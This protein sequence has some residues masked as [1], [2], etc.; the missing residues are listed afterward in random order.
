MITNMAEMQSFS[1]TVDEYN[2]SRNGRSGTVAPTEVFSLVVGVWNYAA[3]ST[4]GWKRTEKHI[5]DVIHKQYYHFKSFPAHWLQEKGMNCP[6][7]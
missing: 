2:I 1:V 4:Y 7:L 5:W 6:K 3:H